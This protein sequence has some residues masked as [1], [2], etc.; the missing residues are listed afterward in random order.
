MSDVR[1]QLRQTHARARRF[2]VCQRR[3]RAAD[4]GGAALPVLCHLACRILLEQPGRVPRVES[5]RGRGERGWLALARR[6]MCEA[7]Q[8]AKLDATADRQRSTHR[9]TLSR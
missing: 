6:W 9:N 8:T 3:G 5:G 1:R 2:A 4:R 7:T